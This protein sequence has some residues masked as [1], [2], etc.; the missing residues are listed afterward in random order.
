ML[1]VVKLLVEFYDRAVF[2][3][4]LV[5]VFVAAVFEFH[6]VYISAVFTVKLGMQLADLIFG[7]SRVA[8]GCCFGFIREIGSALPEAVAVFVLYPDDIAAAGVDT[9]LIFGAAAFK[10]DFVY[11]ENVF[12]IELDLDILYGV[13]AETGVGEGSAERRV[14]SDVGFCACLPMSAD[15]G[16]LL[17]SCD[18][19]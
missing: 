17:A 10:L 2:R 7:K 15:V 8:Q 16:K 4:D 3:V 6:L 11:H 9:V 1:S 5:V 14:I 18:E 12:I 19:V 13:A